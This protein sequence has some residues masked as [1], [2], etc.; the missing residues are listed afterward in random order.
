MTDF[1]KLY[2]NLEWISI[3]M[4]LVILI[5]YFILSHIIKVKKESFSSIYKFEKDNN[6]INRLDLQYAINAHEQG[7]ICG[8]SYIQPSNACSFSYNTNFY[9]H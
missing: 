8:T 3:G 2:D 4:C 7:T 1:Y 6:T 9:P 5:L